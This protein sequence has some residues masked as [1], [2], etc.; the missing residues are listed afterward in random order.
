MAG[1][2]ATMYD[3]GRSVGKNGTNNPSDVMLVQF[4]LFSIF[5]N[6]GFPIAGKFGLDQALDP[7]AIFPINGVATPELNRW[8]EMFQ[9]LANEAGQGPLFVDG[10]VD[11]SN[12]G[13]GLRT[14]RTAGR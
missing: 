11:P 5:M 13:W 14:G 4:F 1:R 9:R 7:K 2:I 12:V 3:I 6:S 10:R 8:I